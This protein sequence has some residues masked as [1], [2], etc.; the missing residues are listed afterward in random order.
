MSIS[1]SKAILNGAAWLGGSFLIKL[2]LRIFSVAILARL[3]SPKEYGI[4]AGALIVMELAAMLYQLG[5]GTA[6]VQRKV[7]TQEHISTA[8]FF[9]LCMSLLTGIGLWIFAPWLASIMKMPEIEDVLRVLAFFTPLGAF[10]VL[11]EAVLA[12]NMKARSIAVRQLISFTISVYGV[13]IPL[14]MAGF[15]YWSLVAMQASEIFISAIFLAMTTRKYLFVPKFT[16]GAFKELWPMSLTFSVNQP[17]VYVSGNAD[18]F[19]VSRLL[20]MESLGLYTR[21]AFVTTT[22]AN[23][24]GNIARISIFPAMATIQDDPERLKM[25]LLRSA[26]LLASITIPASIYFAVF[27]SEIIYLLLGNQ[28]GLASFPFAIFSLMLFPKLAH[29]NLVAFLQSIGQSHIVL[30][31]HVPVI[32]ITITGILVLTPYEIKKISLVVGI[33][34][35]SGF[36]TSVFIVA[37]KTEASIRTMLLAHGGSIILGAFTLLAC[38]ATRYALQES[39]P[40]SILF[41]GIVAT[42]FSI[43]LAITLFRQVIFLYFPSTSFI[44]LFR[45]IK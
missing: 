27:S 25:A 29:R 9:T 10:N 43:L 13:A 6:L 19:L 34:A 35:L 23:V 26:A 18:K 16:R 37:Y 7:T 2:G 15:G 40:L 1:L 31:S 5:L 36:I 24:F 20:G 41:C 21:A 30:I 32:A 39:S 38:L 28:W 14:A 33:A 17:F 11:C 8:L 42:A 44:G 12:R 3:L 22:A 45:N 4:V